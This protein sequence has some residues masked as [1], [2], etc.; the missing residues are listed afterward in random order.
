MQSQDQITYYLDNLSGY[1]SR[2][3][4]RCKRS[5]SDLPESKL[6]RPG[7]ISY[8]LKSCDGQDILAGFMVLLL[9]ITSHIPLYYITYT[10][11]S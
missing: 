6:L 2:F 9:Y 10:D 7:V 3:K 8:V 1:R 11:F 4:T 5:G